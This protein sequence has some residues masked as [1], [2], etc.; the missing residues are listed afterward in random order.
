MEK[1]E[2]VSIILPVYNGEQYLKQSIESCLNQTYSNIELIIVNDCSTDATLKIVNQYLAIDNR[3]RVINNVINKKLPA[4]LNIGHDQ[5]KGAYITWT[6]D[7]NYYDLLAI[8][9]MVNII[10]QEKTDIV[11][12]N[13]NMING[14]ENTVV[15][16]LDF[17]NLLQLNCI[18]ACFLYNNQVYKNS[19]KYDESLFLVEDYDFWLQ[20]LK[21]YKFYHLPKVLYHYRLHNA[22][23]TQSIQV[24]SE[25]NQLFVKNIEVSYK[26]F[27]S[28][29]DLD[30]NYCAKLFTKLHIA[31]YSIKNTREIF[32]IRAVV[33]VC[34]KK[35][36]LSK[37]N[38]KAWLFSIMQLQ[39]QLLR[40]INK[41]VSF[42]SC[43]SFLKTNYKLMTY[44]NYKVWIKLCFR[45]K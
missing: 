9:T 17:Y 43:L 32:D 42:Y 14:N 41:D 15:K 20:S 19:E 21:K 22:S 7:D 37:K 29:F 40:S 13:Y 6:S 24:D 10:L 25:R 35:L 45:L 27:F 12:A 30:V 38:K 44:K 11:Y 18:G 36:R 23:L 26:K 34:S 1:T 28:S 2:L 16:L 4:S 31:P 33:N 5:A 3:V 39:L 8:E